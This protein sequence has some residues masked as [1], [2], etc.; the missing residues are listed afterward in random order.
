MSIDKEVKIAKS[1]IV[2][3]FDSINTIEKFK[4]LNLPIKKEYKCPDNTNNVAFEIDLS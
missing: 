3:L 4:A 1:P 2:K